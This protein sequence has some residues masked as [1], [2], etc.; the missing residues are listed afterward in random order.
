ME[1]DKLLALTREF[2]EAFN[3]NDLEAV[4]SYFA[5]D[6]VYDESNG[7]TNRRREPIRSAFD[8]QVRGAFGT[9]AF[10]EEDCCGDAEAGKAVISWTVTLEV[11][12]E[13]VAWRGLDILHVEDGLIT[14]KLTYAKAKAPLFV[15]RT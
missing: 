2:T 13:P 11:K 10:S 12:G 15:A 4:M 14:R 8:P 6:A 7:T 3:R 5:D 1:R 9:T